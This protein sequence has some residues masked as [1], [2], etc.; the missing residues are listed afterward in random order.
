MPVNLSVA[1]AKVISSGSELQQEVRR[2]EKNLF[3]RFR[4]I[5]PVLLT[6]C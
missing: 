6:S 1:A 2:T 3:L 5:L 4:G